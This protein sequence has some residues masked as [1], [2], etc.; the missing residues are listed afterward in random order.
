[1]RLPIPDKVYPYQNLCMI[2]KIGNSVFGGNA[3]FFS[4]PYISFYKETDFL[5]G[6]LVAIAMLKGWSMQGMPVL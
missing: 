1:M 4:M 6:L 5:A 2:A 3:C